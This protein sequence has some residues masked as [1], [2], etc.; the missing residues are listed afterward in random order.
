MPYLRALSTFRD[1][2]RGLAMAKGDDALK[3]ILLLC[4]TL[5]DTD[6]VPLG[7]ALDDQ[8][9]TIIVI[10][11]LVSPQTHLMNRWKGSGETHVTARPHQGP[12]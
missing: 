5:R 12:R 9:G 7:V 8:P 4:D 6:L 3:E 2:V 1:G 10:E 11:R